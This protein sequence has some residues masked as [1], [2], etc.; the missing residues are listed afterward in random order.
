MATMKEPDDATA[1]AVDGL[2]VELY[3]ELRVIAHRHL[4]G[5]REGQTLGTTGLVHESFLRLSMADDGRWRDRAQFF[6]LAS[7]AMRN[8]LV[9]RARARGAVKRGSAAMA[10]TLDPSLAVGAGT[11]ILDLLALNEAMAALGAQSARLEQVVE[12]KV[13]GG[14]STEETAETLGVSVRTVERDWTR[15]RAYLLQL[16]SDRMT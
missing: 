6:A 2:Y 13:F 9:D 10:I 8:I 5:D 12:C 3:D 7:K 14:L 11:D 1:M 16:L 4:R 15:A